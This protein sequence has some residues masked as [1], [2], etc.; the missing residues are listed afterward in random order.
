MRWIMGLLMAVVMGITGC[1]GGGRDGLISG[2][3]TTTKVVYY[4]VGGV[5]KSVTAL[6]CPS[7][8]RPQQ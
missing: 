2:Q 1:S 5:T 7:V 4:T 6:V 8:D 3:K